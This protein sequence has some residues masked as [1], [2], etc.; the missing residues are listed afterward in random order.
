MK[1][2]LSLF[3]AVCLLCGM[4][5]MPV[6]AATTTELNAGIQNQD[7]LA[8]LQFRQ[9]EAPGKMVAQIRNCPRYVHQLLCP[10][11][12]RKRRDEPMARPEGDL[13]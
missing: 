10:T 1:K 2:Y 7:A 11:F 6:S 13:S 8:E 9:D 4:L 5:V 12:W 3:L